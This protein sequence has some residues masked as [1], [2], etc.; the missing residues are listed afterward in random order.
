MGFLSRFKKR[1]SFS[2]HSIPLGESS[3]SIE[4][5]DF[6][7]DDKAE[8]NRIRTLYNL[9][10]QRTK[11]ARVIRGFQNFSDAAFEA[12]REFQG[13][14]YE[15]RRGKRTGDIDKE[16]LRRL[17]A[18]EKRLRAQ[19]RN[20]IIRDRIENTRMRHAKRP[21]YTPK[22]NLPS[23]LANPVGSRSYS[24]ARRVTRDPI[25][26]NLVGRDFGLL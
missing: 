21:R 26:L 18:E 22:Y 20:S 24:R 10:Q 4:R 19:E 23:S 7:K 16:E 9:S 3:G 1:Q 8:A 6:S 5:A 11:K 14:N 2:S 25:G 12:Q 15:K 13:K 17:R